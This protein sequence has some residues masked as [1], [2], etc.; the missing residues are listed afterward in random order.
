MYYV[1]C[2]IVCLSGSGMVRRT[3]KNL[4][5]LV[6]VKLGGGYE[7]LPFFLAHFLLASDECILARTTTSVDPNLFQPGSPVLQHFCGFAFH[8]PRHVAWSNEAVTVPI[9]S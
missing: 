9:L 8:V 6:I 3:N 2:A 1:V 4:R 7:A 5:M